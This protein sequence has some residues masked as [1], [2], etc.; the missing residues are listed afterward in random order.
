MPLHFRPYLSGLLVA[1]ALLAGCSTAGSPA[2]AHQ[3]EAVMPRP[4]GYIP[5]QNRTLPAQ[6]ETWSVGEEQVD[7]TLLL[8]EGNAESPLLLYLPGLGETAD[9]GAAWRRAWAQAGYAVVAVQPGAFGPAVWQSPQAR[10]GDF[11]GVAKD[12]FSPPRFA[13]RLAVVR[14]VLDE[15]QRR[16][17]KG[18]YPHIDLTRYAVAGFDLGAQTGMALAG[19]QIEGIATPSLPATL[20]AIIALSPYADFSGMSAAPLFSS[21]RLPVLSITSL[22]DTDQY[23]LVTSAA[24][25]RAP[26]QYMPPG[27][28]YLLVLSGANHALLSGS[29]ALIPGETAGTPTPHNN[30]QSQDGRSDKRSGGMGGSGGRRSRSGEP[31][32]GRP[33]QPFAINTSAT[34]SEQGRNIA[35]VTTAYL[36]AVVKNDPVAW[37]WLAKDA[38]RW[39]GDSAQLSAK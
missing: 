2:K 29:E 8:P 32:T 31:G 15:L 30:Q 16:K 11:H 23:G 24:V 27:N 22:E 7:V 33:V 1:L 6:R 12:A 38:R 37:E 39:L 21:V 9:A 19:Q 10:A 34:W 28:K 26:F 20:K 36:D 14:G 17:S 4:G 3:P 5:E 25:R 13:A 35:G 18:G